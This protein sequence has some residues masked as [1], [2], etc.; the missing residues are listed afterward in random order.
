[1]KMTLRN[2]RARAARV[3]ATLAAIVGLV[4]VVGVAPASAHPLDHTNPSTTG[5]A[6]GSYAIYSK[7]I[8]NGAGTTIGMMEV[9]YSPSCGTNWVRVNNYGYGPVAGKMVSVVGGAYDYVGDAY[10]GWSYGN[11]LYAPGSTCII[12]EGSIRSSSNTVI[13]STGYIQLC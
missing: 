8:K 11:Q 2:Y 6:S 4:L 5:C 10:V 9:R 12:V 7:A 13:G 3:A 1:M